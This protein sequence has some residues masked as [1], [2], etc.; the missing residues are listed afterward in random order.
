MIALDLSMYNLLSIIQKILIVILKT[1]N[2][3]FEILTEL[4][5]L[6]QVATLAQLVRAVVS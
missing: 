1:F 3:Y 4:I 6:H 5:T 2:S